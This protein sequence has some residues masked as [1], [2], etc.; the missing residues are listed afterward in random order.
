MWG[1]PHPAHTAE[2]LSYV[3]EV[4]TFGFI[5]AVNRTFQMVSEDE[6]LQFARNVKS[7]QSYIGIKL[8]SH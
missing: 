8:V 4:E 5:D 2:L 1:C 6:E 3:T 7:L